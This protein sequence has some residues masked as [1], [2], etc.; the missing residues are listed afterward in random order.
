MNYVTYPHACSDDADLPLAWGPI[1]R[2]IGKCLAV[3]GGGILFAATLYVM[4]VLPD[5]L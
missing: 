2:A 4:L 5:L 1:L 3:L